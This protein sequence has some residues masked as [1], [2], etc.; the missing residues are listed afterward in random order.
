MCIACT[1]IELL[2]DIFKTERTHTFVESVHPD[3]VFVT[4]VRK[5]K[6]LYQTSIVWEQNNIMKLEPTTLLHI[7]VHVYTIL[8][9]CMIVIVRV[10]R[11]MYPWRMNQISDAI[12]VVRIVNY[13][14]HDAHMLG[15]IENI[16]KDLIISFVR[17]VSQLFA[18]TIPW[19][20]RE[21]GKQI[22]SQH[23][24]LQSFFIMPQKKW[25][26]GERGTSASS[27]ERCMRY[28]PILK[29][30]KNRHRSR[31]VFFFFIFIAILCILCIWS[32]VHT[33]A[34]T[35]NRKSV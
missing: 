22:N 33:C 7:L 8:T 31:I 10:S 15:L 6:V 29:I 25:Q 1:C 5:K 18:E 24:Q 30:Q 28:N 2:L 14:R 32:I 21:R 20:T 17:W 3:L 13:S 19:I 11:L 26:V 27:T 9:M 4:R 12:Y 35:E 34:A 23:K 16:S